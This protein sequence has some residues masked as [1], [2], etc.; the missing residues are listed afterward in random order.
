MKPISIGEIADAV[1]GKLNT[2]GIENIKV[3]TISTDTRNIKNDGKNIL[4]IP[5]KG[6]N[7]DGHNYII[8]AFENGVKFSLSENNIS[9]D[10]DKNIIIVK[11]TKKALAD[12]ARYYLSKFDNLPVIAVTGSVGKTT[13]KDTIASVLSQKF[14]VLKTDGNFNNEIGL[15][16]TIFNIDDNTQIV[17][18]EMG[19]NNF[20]EI[21]RLSSIAT[22]DIAIITNIGVSH[23]ENLGSR[24]G[25]LKAKCEIFD[26]LKP[27]GIGIINADDD[28]LVKIKDVPN[29]IYFGT[30]ESSFN[31]FFVTNVCENGLEGISFT[32]NTPKGDFFVDL[33]TAGKYM[34]YNSL[35]ATIVGQHFGLSNESIKVGIES[36]KSGKMRGNIIKTEKYTIIDD[37]YNASPTS[38][39]SS[40]DTLCS[41]E[42]RKVAILG[43]MF[44]LGTYSDK[45]HYEIGEYISKSNV[46]VLIAVGKH[47]ENIKLGVNNDNIDTFYFENQDLLLDEIENILQ[48]GDF[49]LVKASRGMKLEKT[50]DKIKR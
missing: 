19:M 44:E 8:K 11:D 45:F 3:N 25:I 47:S 46:D 7:F 35:I 49:V 40:I 16:L 30:K 22:P 29:L 36:F 12:L 26:F 21:H 23:I 27:D 41:A 13:T 24:E 42:G 1:G 39:K 50:V 5:L 20:G 14:N 28:M 4:F 34:V 9:P 37:V 6:D 15:P 43:D 48:Y 33:K 10:I 17:I 31:N 18:L 2:D 38:M 32:I